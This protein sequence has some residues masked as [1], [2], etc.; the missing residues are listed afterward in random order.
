MNT[1]NACGDDRLQ[2]QTE[3]YTEQNHFTRF[4]L[5]KRKKMVF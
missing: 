1:A 4:Y 3:I 5:L 2:K